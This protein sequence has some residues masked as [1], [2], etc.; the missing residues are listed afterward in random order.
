MPERRDCR[1]TANIETTY[2]LI[3]ERVC[4]EDGLTESQYLR[5][6]LIH[7]FNKRKLLTHE[8]LLRL[9]TTDSIEQMEKQVATR[10]LELGVT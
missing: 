9:A 3:M 10:Q 6:L 8:L 7:D 2:K 5:Q 1:I 4:K